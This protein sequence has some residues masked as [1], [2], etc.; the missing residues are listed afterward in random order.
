[1]T[2]STSNTHELDINTLV[3]TAYQY[4]GVMNEM[5][6]ASGPQWDARS[7]YGRTHLELILDGLIADGIFV[8]SVELYEL[9]I[10]AG[11]TRTALPADTVDV[12]G[13]AVLVGGEGDGTV[14]GIPI[15]AI[16]RE[17]YHGLI[18]PEQ[19]GATPSMF[20]VER[21]AP[22]YLY[23][24]PVPDSALTI[25][26]QRQRLS[27][28][29]TQGSATVDLERFWSEFIVHELAARIALTN[30][31]PTDRITLLQA[32]AQVAKQAAR[33]KASDQ[34]DNRIIVNHPGPYRR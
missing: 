1:M 3:L 14:T 20:Y 33:G 16:N 30:G 11:A 15:K 34:L 10:E 6:T 19:T 2:I 28:D 24:W 13:E 32:K 31:L 17:K 12:R 22:M 23:L 27:Y 5:Q 4:A 8:R 21:T 29:S 7:R 9:D 26:I 18:L 25:R